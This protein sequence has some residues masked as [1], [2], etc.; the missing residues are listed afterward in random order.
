MYCQIK[1]TPEPKIHG[2]GDDVRKQAL[3][4]YVDGMNLRRIGRQLGI[5]HRTV[6]LWVKASAASLPEALQDADALVLLVGHTEL[7]NID[8]LEAA[9][10]TRARL[11][12]T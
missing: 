4:M 9:G 5:N 3:Q 1:Y 7:K 6:S 12:W 10:M 2:Y 11:P 8:P